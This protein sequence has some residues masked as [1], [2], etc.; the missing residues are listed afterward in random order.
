MTEQAKERLRYKGKTYRIIAEPLDP[1]LSKSNKRK[2]LISPNT[3]CWRGYYG[4]WKIKYNKLYLVKLEAYIG[5]YKEV[6]MDYFFPGGKEVFADWFNGEII[7]I[8]DDNILIG[9]A[10]YSH[11]M[12]DYLSLKFKNGELIESKQNKNQTNEI[13]PKNFR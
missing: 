7:I 8:D 10:F 1:Y 9:Y 4:T 3:A 11:I 13:P 6:G 12:G 2:D 5:D